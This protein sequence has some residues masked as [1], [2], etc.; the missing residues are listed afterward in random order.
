MEQDSLAFLHKGACPCGPVEPPSLLWQKE[1]TGGVGASQ[2][3]GPSVSLSQLP[4]RT[5]TSFLRLQ[6]T[7]V[8]QQPGRAGEQSG[9]QSLRGK[10]GKGPQRPP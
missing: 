10:A 6:G 5:G 1:E 9:P 8:G 2:P 7:E 4:L 3:R